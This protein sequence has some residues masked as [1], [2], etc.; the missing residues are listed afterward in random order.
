M[1]QPRGPY[2]A[3]AA[4]F[5]ITRESAVSWFDMRQLLATGS[6]TLAATIV[7]SMS[8]RREIMAAL[9]PDCASLPSYADR[10]EL[11]I[12]YVADTGDGWNATMSIAWLIGRDALELDSAGA[13]R[14]QPIP[15]NCRNEAEAAKDEA[16]RLPYGQ[17]LVV[18]GDQVYPTASPETYQKRFAHPLRCARYTQTPNRAIYALPGNHDW[19]D[20]LTS[21]IR[22]FCQVGDA[23]RWYGA[24]RAEQRRSYFAL[25][26]PHRWWLWGVDMALED[27]LD[28]PQYDYFRAEAQKLKPG[29]KVILCVPA[30][31][32]IKS[33]GYD[34]E[35]N[36]TQLRM[37]DKL[38]IIMNLARRK[39]HSVAVPVVL[40]G[41]LHYY[42]RHRAVIDDTTR[43]YVVCGGGGAFGLGTLQTPPSLDVPNGKKDRA[44]ATLQASFPDAEQ[45]I[46]LRRGVLRF[47]IKNPLFTLA[48][49]C[50]QLILLWLLSA[51]PPH[52]RPEIP[53]EEERQWIAHAMCLPPDPSGLGDFLADT[54][55]GLASLGP[56]LWALAI[57]LG[58]IGFACSGK[59]RGVSNGAAVGAGLVH[60]MIQIAG[61]MSII[62]LA[63]RLIA[64][65]GGGNSAGDQWIAVLV[66]IIP[67]FLF[68]GF[69]FGA[70]L[71]LCHK[72]IGLH[73]QEV[74]SAQGIEG[75]K[76]FLRM[77][78]SR[79][80]VTIYPIG[81][82]QQARDW[83]AA[84]GVKLG[85]PTTTRSM[86][87]IQ[88]VDVPE[89]CLRVL[90]PDQPLEPHLIEPAFTV[91]GRPTP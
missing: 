54:V 59:P 14:P 52:A 56:L 15:K 40:T 22:L 66:A 31:S 55:R 13:P 51:S 42:A 44:R 21:F 43:D 67:L 61:S 89:G 3:P 86:G 33:A 5:R 34:S 68:C 18:G 77:R 63:A 28:P 87:K 2:V 65:L 64:G 74:F 80:G 35:L 6:K 32:W 24:W 78:V 90:D 75:F 47:P 26:L 4:R 9:D 30:P 91:T 11:W 85:E 29:D 49:A 58:F 79:E 1:N 37:A 19:Y 88:D 16:L 70:Y 82:R 39:D 23:R 20:G 48:V 17:I 41:D 8:G 84:G 53:C 27:D 62:W 60:G 36:K 76:C 45:S 69:L 81:L 83:R 38:D 10:D 71:L 25:E 12:D 57:L 73:D 72:F 50:A 46:K 7:G